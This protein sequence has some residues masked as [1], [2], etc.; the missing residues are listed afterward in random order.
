MHCGFIPRREWK[1]LPVWGQTPANWPAGGMVG[2]HG[3]VPGAE[4]ATRDPDTGKVA[5]DVCPGW[6]GSRPWLSGAVKATE[7]FEKGAL[8]A[9]FPNLGNREAEAVIELS[10]ASGAHQSQRMD[11]ARAEAEA[12]RKADG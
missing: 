4:Y 10:R 3:F 11:A 6:A 8:E 9:L 1:S 2:K 12:K 5:P 7:A